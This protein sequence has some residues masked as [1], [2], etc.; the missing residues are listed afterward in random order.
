MD[1]RDLPRKTGEITKPIR[2]VVT[3]PPYFDVTNFEEDQWLRLW[4]LGGSP[5]PTRNRVS[6]DD[7]HEDAAKYWGMVG[8][9]WR[10]LGQVLAPKASVVVRI[11]ST[12]VTPKGLV[13]GLEGAAM[14]A[15]R[16]V[17][18]VSS[19]VSKIARRQTDAFRPGTKGCKVEVDCHFLVN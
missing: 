15:G 14:L 9:M 6:R 13:S 7:R 8:D 19:H 16:K 4:F 5:A 12:R 10:S 11:G 1:M 2:C 18:L 3:S 17:R